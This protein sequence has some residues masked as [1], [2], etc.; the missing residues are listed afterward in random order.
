LHHH[1]ESILLA[2]IYFL[3]LEGHWQHQ[4]FKQQHQEGNVA[5]QLADVIEPCSHGANH[6]STLNSKD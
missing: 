5:P 2:S 3:T 6:H 4:N 1:H